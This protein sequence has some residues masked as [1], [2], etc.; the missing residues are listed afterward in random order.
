MG[1]IILGIYL[2][3]GILLGILWIDWRERR[4]WLRWFPP[5]SFNMFFASALAVFLVALFW[6]LYALARRVR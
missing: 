2:A 5:N 1:W 6:P 4:F 3:L